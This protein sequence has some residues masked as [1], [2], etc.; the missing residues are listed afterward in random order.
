MNHRRTFAALA[1]IVA[2]AMFTP[3]VAEPSDALSDGDVVVST[4]DGSSSIDFTIDSGHSKTVQ[5]YIKNTTNSEVILSDISVN[6]LNDDISAVVTSS[7]GRLLDTST[8]VTTVTIVFS[9]GNYAD[10]VSLSGTVHIAAKSISDNKSALLE[11]SIPLNITIHSVFVDD[12][13]YNKFFGV[14]AN[15]FDA[16]LNNPW[17]TASVT[18][19]IW[20]IATIIMSEIIIP[21]LTHFVGARKTPE[22][23][24]SLTKRLTATITALMVVI[25]FNECAHIVGAN[26]EVSHMVGA[27]SNVIYVVLGSVIA[28]QVYTFIISAFLKGLDENAD[29]DGMDMSLLPLFK[30]IGKLVIGVS[31]VCAALAAFG[32]DLA[33]IMVSAGVVTLGITLGAQNTLNQFFSGIV[34]LATR[35]FK[36]GDFVQIAGTSYIVHKV[37]LMY[38]EFENW[39]KDQIVTIPNNVVSS[40]TLVNLTKNHHRTRVFVYIDV[41]Y[42]S[43]IP[44]VKA[45]LERAG[46]KHPHVIV[47]G[48][49]SPPGSRL[50]EFADNGIRF[51]LSCY[52]D[53]Y[54]NSSHYAGQIRELVWQELM[55]DNIN[56]PYNRIQVDILSEPAQNNGQAGYQSS[57]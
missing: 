50:I 13:S 27:I 31:A 44:K 46:R 25:A 19:I 42:D 14:F 40:A 9:A 26:A 22:E 35:P 4:S 30:M 7:A 8:R 53:D 55:D 20:I 49:C 41:S 17:I 43:D 6:G 1:V 39:D 48:S 23:K 38:T 10:N 32:V 52:V 24:K 11:K 33:G 34:L 56:V 29:V 2:L 3:L 15:T 47:D 28:W 57:F 54:D 21:M 5:I 12:G 16:P 37:R 36:K 45:C 18:M 51:R